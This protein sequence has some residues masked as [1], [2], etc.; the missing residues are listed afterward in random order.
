MVSGHHGIGFAKVKPNYN[1]YRSPYGPDYK[2]LPNVR[3]IDFR[4][5]M[6]FGTTAAG[7]GIVAGIFAMQFFSDVPKVRTDIMQ[8]LPVVGEYF[9][10]EVPP[11]DNP[12]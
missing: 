6:K 3:G 4:R 2:V 1:T 7:F 5:A 10:R 12:F 9:V 8:K 11:E